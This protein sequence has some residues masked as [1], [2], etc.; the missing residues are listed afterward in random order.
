VTTLC[1]LSE[2]NQLPVDAFAVGLKPLFESAGPLAQ[3]LHEKRPFASYADL[4]ERA[5]VLANAM[6]PIDKAAVLNA[7]P[8]IGANPTEVSS[9]SFDE[10]G[11]VREAA[12]PRAELERTYSRLA[13]VNQL[14]EDRFGF[15]FVVFVN[16][17]P[18][19]AIL[20]VLEE[21]VNNSPEQELATGLG[22][23]FAIARDRLRVL[24]G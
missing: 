10:Q 20:E 14:Y 13:E 23:M 11:Y 1:P 19:A 3:R 4:I 17:R 2:L 7:H 16:G 5:E 22:E 21:R 12:A 9:L 15:R 6:P 8:R 24:R 18:K